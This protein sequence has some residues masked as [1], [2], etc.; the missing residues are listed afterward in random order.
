MF[1]NIFPKPL[2]H[3]YRLIQIRQLQELR[4]RRHHS[5]PLLVKDQRQEHAHRLPD[6]PT[7]RPPR[8]Q[9]RECAPRLRAESEQT[10]AQHRGHA[11]RPCRQTQP[12]LRF[13]RGAPQPTGEPRESL[14]L[15]A[16]E[17]AEHFC[18]RSPLH[19]QE[20]PQR[21]VGSLQHRSGEEEQFAD[22]PER[23][24]CQV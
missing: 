21:Q 23:W 10:P 19:L 11:L 4:T 22:E 16:A 18:P 3:R 9:A 6:R 5:R 12:S 7:L 15:P 20:Q 8:L 1:S 14:R 24:N 13:P 2:T 17:H